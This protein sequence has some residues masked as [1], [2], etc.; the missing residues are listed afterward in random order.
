MLAVFGIVGV[1]LIGIVFLFLVW[2]I[3]KNIHTQLDF[4]CFSISLIL[5]FI[6]GF[7]NPALTEEALLAA[8][9]IAPNSS[10]LFRKKGK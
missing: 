7:L 5:I 4:I 9:V 8:L 1:I 3:Y 10:L 2:Q 6:L